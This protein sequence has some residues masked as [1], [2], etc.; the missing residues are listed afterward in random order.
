MFVILPIDQKMS[1]EK[2][3]AFISR[4]R[5]WNEMEKSFTDMTLTMGSY[6]KEILSNNDDDVKNQLFQWRD[7]IKKLNNAWARVQKN[8]N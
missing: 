5:I 1:E 2:I 6:A 7:E 4:L 3:E 8:D